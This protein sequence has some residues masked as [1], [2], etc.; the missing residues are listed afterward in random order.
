[1]KQ[2]EHLTLYFYQDAWHSVGGMAVDDPGCEGWELVSTAPYSNSVVVQ[3]ATTIGGVYLPPVI[4]TRN[5]VLGFF[6][7]E[8]A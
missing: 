6:K 4:K 3:E 2:W 1:M 5:E 7:R 8:V